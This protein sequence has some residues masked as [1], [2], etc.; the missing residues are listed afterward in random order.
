MQGSLPAILMAN[1]P[2]PNLF[3][4]GYNT[5]RTPSAPLAFKGSLAILANPE[6]REGIE[7]GYTLACIE[8]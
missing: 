4:E 5:F 2:E 1:L 7:V 8:L 3:T 6:S